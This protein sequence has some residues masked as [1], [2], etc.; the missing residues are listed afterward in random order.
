VERGFCSTPL[1]ESWQAA[2]DAGTVPHEDGEQALVKLVAPDGSLLV[3][4]TMPG[5]RNELRWFPAGGTAPTVV[6]D[7][8]L[9][10]PEWQVLGASF[11]G[12]YLAYSVTHSFRLFSSDWTLYVWDSQAGGEPSKIAESPHGANDEPIARPLNYPVAYDGQV[13][14]V[15]PTGDQPEQTALYR[16]QVEDGSREVLHAGHPWFPFRMGSLLVWPESPAEGALTRLRA[17]SLDTGRP[18]SLPGPLSDIEGP[19]FIN[20]DEDTVAWTDPEMT[21]LWVWR[22][23]WPAPVRVLRD[24][25]VPVEWLQV[26]GEIVAWNHRERGQFALDL[27]SGGYSQ[28]TPEWGSTRSGG[29]FLMVG[30]APDLSGDKDSPVSEQTVV[31]TRKLPPLPAC[32]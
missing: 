13:V 16:Y 2:L 10:N 15:Q 11:D 18:A 12:R 22:T 1:P 31:D 3:Q 29:S 20:A 24:T 25:E 8:G 17:V 27:R 4:S 7:F 30:Y 14:W 9:D 32:G 6:H 21:E 23:G 28:L 19:A 5:R 26:A